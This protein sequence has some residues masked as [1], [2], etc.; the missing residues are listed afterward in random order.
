[1]ED[2]V[3]GCHTDLHGIIGGECHTL[4]ICKTTTFQKYCI[5]LCIKGILPPKEE[6]EKIIYNSSSIFL[7]HKTIKQQELWT[8]HGFIELVT[9]KWILKV[10][11]QT[12][13]AVFSILVWF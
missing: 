6:K 3:T 8:T 11:T 9:F 10:M 5:H 1:M 2:G 13:G 4:H 7:A 12:E